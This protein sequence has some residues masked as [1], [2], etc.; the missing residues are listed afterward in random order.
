MTEPHDT[1][2]GGQFVWKEVSL[3]RG[4]RGV[5]SPSPHNSDPRSWVPGSAP[6][7]AQVSG[8]AEPALTPVSQLPTCGLPLV[9]LCVQ[10]LL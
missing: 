5:W 3:C 10:A 6:P 7:G 4:T 9:L 1:T 2:P 8:Q